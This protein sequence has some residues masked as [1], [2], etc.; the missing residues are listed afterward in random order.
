[1]DN[2]VDSSMINKDAKEIIDKLQKIIKEMNSSVQLVL[3]LENNVNGSIISEFNNAVDSAE[4][5]K[6]VVNSKLTYIIRDSSSPK[7]DISSIDLDSIR[8]ATC[9][10]V[11][12]NVDPFSDSII[13]LYYNKTID[14]HTYHKIT[15]VND[16]N[17]S[18]IANSIHKHYTKFFS[19]NQTALDI[20]LI[21]HYYNAEKG[22][23]M[24]TVPMEIL[25]SL[26]LN[27]TPYPVCKY[28]TSF[29]EDI[30]SADYEYFN[31]SKTS[32]CS[33]PIMRKKN[34]IF[35][36]EKL[37]ACP[38]ADQKSISQLSCSVYEPSSNF[39]ISAV[40]DFKAN[41]P[42]V[43]NV[44]LKSFKHRNKAEKVYTVF[45][46]GFESFKFTCKDEEAEDIFNKIVSDLSVKG[47]TFI[48]SKES[49]DKE[50]P[51]KKTFSFIKNIMNLGKKNV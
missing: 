13:N 20:S 24:Y 18:I 15:S 46:D 5:I 31:Q 3:P 22:I 30:V 38:Y 40:S 32:T 34:N 33:N 11:Y 8:P 12:G 21:E 44:V 28:Y 49:I 6:K 16:S 35:S 25:F 17:F 23:H 48:H 27:A 7:Q 9:L 26:E 2:V 36:L 39:E 45:C 47:Q 51:E 29:Q 42:I 10:I 50:S 4:D 43:T 37:C 19:G 41:D 14:K 1:M